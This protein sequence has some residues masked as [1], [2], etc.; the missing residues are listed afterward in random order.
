MSSTVAA[1]SSGLVPSGVAVIRVSGPHVR[2]ALQSMVGYVPQPRVAH[3]RTLRE[4]QSRK[5]LDKALVL[6]FQGPASFTG[7]DVAEFHCHG[8]RAVVDGVLSAL[9][10]LD[11][12]APAQ[13]GDFTRQAFS[14]G[15]LD[16]TQVEAV[17]DLIHAGTAAQREQALDQLGGAAGRQLAFW[18]DEIADMRA[19]IEADLDFSDEDDV[20]GSVIDSLP[21]RLA[22]LIAAMEAEMDQGLAE[23]L[24]DGFRVVLAGA[25]N[26]GKSTLLNALL[27]RD[28]ALVSP[29]AGTTRDQLE[30]PI[31]LHGLP[32]LLTDTAGLRDDGADIVEAMGIERTRSAVRQA[33]LTVWVSVGADPDT[34]GGLT[35]GPNSIRIR[36]KSDLASRPDHGG[37]FDL[38]VSALTGD[39]LDALKRLVADRLRSQHVVGSNGEHA[40]GSVV[41]DARR[42]SAVKRTV[43]HLRS[44]K[45]SLDTPVLFLDRAAEDLR[46]AQ[47]ALGEVTGDID[48]EGI[49]DVVFARFCI[50]K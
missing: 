32:V 3:L 26:S 31:D 37:P 34:D 40:V 38:E 1:L 22:E 2:L 16:L 43:D 4:P 17:G 28:A 9:F 25:P 33:D 50:G 14:N 42:R 13:P 21:E 46:L 15:K 29:V 19:S 7:E 47:R 10:S 49:L 12:V 8:G 41:L 5:I 45:R 48:V 23:R 36:S 30:V 20:P 18:R 11:G 35:A 39:G 27:K 24:R 44:S 6:F